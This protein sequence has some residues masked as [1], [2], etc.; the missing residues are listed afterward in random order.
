MALH[1]YLA[2]IAAT[3]LMIALPGPSV[4]LT[5]AHSISFGWRQ[6]LSTVAGATMGIAVQLLVAAIGLASLLHTVAEAFEWVRWAGAAY[7]CYLGVRQWQSAGAAVVVHPPLVSRTNL[8]VQGL[9]VTI[10][11][12]KSLVFIAAFL[13]QFI[14]P[15]HP[16][17]LQLCV[18]VPTFLLIT[19]T[20]TSAWAL[21]AGKASGFLRRRRAFQSVLRTTGGLMILAGAGLVLAK[22][23]S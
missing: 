16:L 17:G 14:D 7:L 9:T 10:P 2:F 12:P 8:F 22:R 20:V 21:A 1:L 15:G 6:A 4:L 23:S 13:P 5:V 19:F 3:T 11:N 18:I